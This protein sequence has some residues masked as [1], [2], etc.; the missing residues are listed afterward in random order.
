MRDRIT[1]LSNPRVKHIISLHRRRVRHR[2]RLFIAEGIRLIEEGLKAKSKPA[3][4]FF[5]EEAASADRGQKLLRMAR[6]MGV[7]LTE[8]SSE[9]MSAMADTENPQGILAAF[10]FVQSSIPTRP[11]LTLVVDGVRDPGNLGT[12][13]RS[14]D[15]AEVDEVLLTRRSVDIYNPKVVRG[16]MGSHFRLPS[17]GGLSWQEIGRAVEGMGVALADA[18]GGERYDDVPWRDPWAV[19][20]GGEAEGSSVEARSL[21]DRLITIPCRQ[22]VESL[23]TAVAGSVILFEA[24]RQRRSGGTT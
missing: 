14:A 18:R 13:L 17:R 23:N 2:E 4:L 24:R 20:V 1:S 12:L 3:A 10:S 16:G 22:G 21:A 6:D 7:M 19:L 8:V 9:V 11:T 15:A 5:T